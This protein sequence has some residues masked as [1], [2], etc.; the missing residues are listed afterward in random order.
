MKLWE[1][2]IKTK[3]RERTTIEENKSGFIAV[4]AT[5]ERIYALQECSIVLDELYFLVI[6]LYGCI[7]L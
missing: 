4:K 5:T 7:A 1:R 3:L 6:D 2:M